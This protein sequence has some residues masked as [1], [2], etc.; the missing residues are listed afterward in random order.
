MLLTS[1]FIF[2]GQK[3]LFNLQSVDVDEGN[4]TIHRSC[5]DVS[6]LDADTPHRRSVIV[7]HL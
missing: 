2:M 5:H 6:I 7:E 3:V 1:P 4:G